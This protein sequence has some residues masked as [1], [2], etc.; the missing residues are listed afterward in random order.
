MD[1][2]RISARTAVESLEKMITLA[3]HAQ[4]TIAR[5]MR[6]PAHCYHFHQAK[7]PPYI[8]TCKI[9]QIVCGL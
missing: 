4:Q 7:I 6:P 2:P 1:M 9:V 8:N 3:I 5:A